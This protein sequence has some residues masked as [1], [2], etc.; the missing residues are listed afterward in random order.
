MALDTKEK[1]AN[2]AR[3][4]RPYLRAKYAV[5]ATTE[6]SRAASSNSYG[7]NAL[8]PSGGG[9]YTPRLTLTGVG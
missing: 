2:A 5:G 1:R 4:A 7:G 3:V 9:G 8:T 6:A